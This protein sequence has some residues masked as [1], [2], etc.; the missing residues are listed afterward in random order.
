MTIG[1]L[2]IEDEKNI[3]ERRGFSARQ[4][5]EHYFKVIF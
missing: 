2:K 1:T 3:E 4:C 5:S